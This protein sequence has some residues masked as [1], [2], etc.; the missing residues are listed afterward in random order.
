MTLSGV[1]RHDRWVL[2]GGLALGVLAAA[3]YTAAGSGIGMAAAPVWTLG[4]AALVFVMWWIMMIAMMTPSAAPVILLFA[5]LKRDAGGITG[6]F[7]SGYLLIWGGFS[8]AATALQWGLNRLHLLSP[9]MAIDGAVLAGTVLILAGFYQLTPLKDACLKQCR[10]PAQFL[11][12]RHR[13]GAT[14]ALRMGLEHGAYCLGCCWAL[15]ALLF[16][17]GVMNL[18]WIVGIAGFVALEKLAPQGRT[19]THILGGILVIA[20]L[21][22]WLV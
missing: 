5:A 3:V 16:V 11:T 7:L 15:M 22:T 6:L 14:G 8:L 4:Y 10:A 13:P 12:E 9:G 1:L 20:G 17:G 21:T 2:P 18:Y 19:L